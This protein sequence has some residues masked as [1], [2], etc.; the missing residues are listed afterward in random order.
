MCGNKK[1]ITYTKGSTLFSIF[2]DYEIRQMKTLDNVVG[3]DAEFDLI[4]QDVQGAEIMV[5]KGSPG[6]FR[7]AKYVIQE[8]NIHKDETFPDMPHEKEMD[9]FMFDLG[10]KDS[11]VIEYK[12]NVKQI[13]KIYF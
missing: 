2:K 3:K 12:E 13:D 1:K 10:F 9:E 11:E 4:K 5:M 7:K 8:V 6:I